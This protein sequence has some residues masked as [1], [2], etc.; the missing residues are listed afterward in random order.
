MT[1]TILSWCHRLYLVIDTYLHKIQD[2]YSSGA[3]IINCKTMFTQNIYLHIF[4]LFNKPSSPPNKTLTELSC[5][6]HNR[7][8]TGANTENMA[9]GGAAVHRWSYYII[10]ALVL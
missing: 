3:H 9:P 2:T 7:N 4:L 1:C 8:T 5:K 6:N 10:F